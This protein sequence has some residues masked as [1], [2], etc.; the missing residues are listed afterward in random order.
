MPPKAFSR[1][2]LLQ[3][4]ILSLGALSA[5]KP[6]EVFSG[7]L[8]RRGVRVPWYRQAQKTTYNYCDMC[9]WR[10]GIIVTS[11][12]GRVHK[13]EATRRIPRAAGNSARAG[14]P[15]SRSCTIPTA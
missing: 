12:N 4:S 6:V 14:R 15:V 5:A 9:P 13:I 1:R 8:A 2:R 10:C 7:F 11:V 3:G